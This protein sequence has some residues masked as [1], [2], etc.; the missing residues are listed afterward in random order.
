MATSTRVHS[1][2][3]DYERR[4]GDPFLA[5]SRLHRNVRA[6]DGVVGWV[7]LRGTAVWCYSCGLTV[8]QLNFVP[9]SEYG[10]GKAPWEM[11]CGHERRYL[12]VEPREFVKNVHGPVT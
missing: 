10:A 12:V 9:G 3:L 8:L 7:W 11:T 4:D 2:H 1:F 6:V 5:V